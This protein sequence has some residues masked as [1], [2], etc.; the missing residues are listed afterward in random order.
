MTDDKPVTAA[1]YGPESLERARALCLELATVIGDFMI[2]DVTVV[3][4]LV[5]PLLIP[6]EEL[7]PGV[8]PHPGTMD[9]DVS[10]S[11]ALLN[12]GRYRDL[13]ARLR[14]AEF[15]PDEARS[16]NRRQGSAFGRPNSRIAARVGRGLCR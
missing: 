13:S 2:E 16:I 5:P 7:G 3:G 12:E 10:L 1:G 15:E 14:D 6:E 9:V 11:L 8:E 4:G